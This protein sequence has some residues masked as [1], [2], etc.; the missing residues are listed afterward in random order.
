MRVSDEF[1]KKIPEHLSWLTKNF[2]SV[3]HPMQL[4][5]QPTRF[6]RGNY[7]SY[8]DLPKRATQDLERQVAAGFVEKLNYNPKIIHS[9]WGSV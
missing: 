6:R 1:V 2:L 9:Q 8:E 5:E 7:R 3:G 4:V